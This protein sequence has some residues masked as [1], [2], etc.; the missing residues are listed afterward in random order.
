MSMKRPRCP[1]SRRRALPWLLAATTL[2]GTGACS[3]HSDER[4]NMHVAS[5]GRDSRTNGPVVVLESDDGAEI[6]HIWIGDGEAQAISMAMRGVEP[7]RPMTHDLMRDIVEHLGARVVEVEVSALRGDTFIATIQ[8][9]A[10]GK[11]IRVDARPSDAIAL[12]LRADSPIRVRHELLEQLDRGAGRGRSARA[13]ESWGIAV[14]NVDDALA[15]ALDLEAP[16]GV[17]INEV[18]AGGIGDAIGLRRG[19]VINRVNAEMILSVQDFARSAATALRDDRVDIILQ[20]DG[21]FFL[22]TSEIP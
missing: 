6:L 11:R 10:R 21:A 7:P 9:E 8:F 1:S 3:N 15:T 17:L 5:I 22:L 13:Q 14:Q 2:M 4:V 19:D 20:R 16:A 18:R 12:S